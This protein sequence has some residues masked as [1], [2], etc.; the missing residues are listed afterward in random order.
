MYIYVYVFLELLQES[1][2]NIATD[3]YGRLIRRRGEH[4]KVLQKRTGRK[5]EV[6]TEVNYF[7]L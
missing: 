4:K 3:R 5:I 7:T 6:R 2:S 1:S